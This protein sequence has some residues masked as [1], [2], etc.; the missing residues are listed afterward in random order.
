MAYSRLWCR[1]NNVSFPF[2][3]TS[4]KTRPEG[5]EDESARPTQLR[6]EVAASL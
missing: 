6:R 4:S 5:G 1:L 2:T 3:M